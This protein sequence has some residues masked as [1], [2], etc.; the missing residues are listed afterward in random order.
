MT[1]SSAMHGHTSILGEESVEL[2]SES[3]EEQEKD[4]ADPSGL[5]I[6]ENDCDTQD[7]LPSLREVSFSAIDWVIARQH[8]GLHANPALRYPGS[9]LNPKEMVSII[10]WYV[11]WNG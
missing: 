5:K 2:S 3:K 11:S 6:K 4:P 7:L 8:V 9:R 10:A 1:D